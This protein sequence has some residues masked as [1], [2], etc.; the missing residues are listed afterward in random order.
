MMRWTLRHA[1]NSPSDRDALECCREELARHGLEFHDAAAGQAPSA[2]K[3]HGMEIVDAIGH[4]SA[5]WLDLRD[6]AQAKGWERGVPAFLHR[7]MRHGDSWYGVPMGIHRAGMAW[8]N[9]RDASQASAPPGSTRDFVSWLRQCGG[10][11]GKPLAVGREAS[12]VGALMEAVVL[13]VCGPVLYRR[14]LECL[15]VQA[16][17]D[18]LMVAAMRCLMELRELVDDRH[19]GLDSHA[20]LERVR[21]GEASVHVMA[22]WLRRDAGSEIVEWAVPGTQGNVVFVADFFVPAVEAGSFASRVV[23][24]ALSGGSFQ[25]E[26]AR[27]KGCLPVVSSAWDG[28]D[29]SL[30]AM[31]D[32]GAVVPSFTF[33]QCCPM[34]S[35]EPL[36]RVL[37]EHFVRRS[38]ALDC[39]GAAV[40]TI[41]RHAGRPVSTTR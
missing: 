4:D 2:F 36:L 9:A 30:R 3:M 34:A 10:S 22:D 40:E 15:D 24:G 26:F 28:I 13:G 31:L 12:Q 41:S 27:R 19:L 38:D 6:L 17:R 32:A 33:D 14:A 25:S 16:W 20:Q 11:A 18:P 21:R 23:A 35:K 37:A 1:W 5:A 7:Y 8:V 29:T 39:I